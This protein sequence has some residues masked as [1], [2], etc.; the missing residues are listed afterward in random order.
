MSSVL[1]DQRCWIHE[2]REAAARCVIC[3]RFFCRECITEHAGQMTCTECVVR[4]SAPQRASERSRTV[5]WAGLAVV[6]VLVAWVVFYY[7][8]Q[9]LAQLP[10]EFHI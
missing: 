3:R 6:G 5:L 8:G 1:T 7:T 4:A 2:E 9:A 10:S